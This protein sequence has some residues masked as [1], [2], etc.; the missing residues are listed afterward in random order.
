MPTSSPVSKK[1]CPKA[2]IGSSLSSCD[3]LPFITGGQTR[4]PSLTV[5]DGIFLTVGLVI[6]V[7][8]F[9]PNTTT[10]VG[11]LYAPGD[12]RRDRAYS[13]FYVGINIGAFLSPLICGTLG[14][15]VG[16]HYGFGAAGVGMLL[17]LAIYMIGFNTLPEDELHRVKAAHKKEAPLTREEWRS[18]YALLVLTIPLTLYWACYEQQG[19]TIALWASD[20][21][22]RTIN[23]L[24]WSG[25]IPITW[26]QSFN[27]FMIFAFTP[28]VVGLWARLAKSGREP[29]TVAKLWTGCLN[30]FM[31]LVQRALANQALNSSSATP[32]AKRKFRNPHC[33]TEL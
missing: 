1:R 22:D 23:L 3:R 10:Q 12:H 9:K 24:F 32:M 15:E 17:A 31:V 2:E 33:R 8:I 29:S 27:P 7:G 13:I 11:S 30:Q 16:W 5:Q 18:V 19:N 26:F 14:E 20:H 4:L 25:E 28:L 6:G 21:T